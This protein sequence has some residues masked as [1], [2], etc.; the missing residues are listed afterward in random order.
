[1]IIKTNCPKCKKQIIADFIPTV[2]SKGIEYIVM[3][4]Y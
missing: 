4:F 1:M 3:N 2:N